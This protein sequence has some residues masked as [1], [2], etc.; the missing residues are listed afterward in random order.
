MLELAK[1]NW[2]KLGLC[3]GEQREYGGLVC[4]DYERI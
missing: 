4:A 1:E 3:W 2:E